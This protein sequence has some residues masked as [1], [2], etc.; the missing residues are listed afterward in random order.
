MHQ[1][2]FSKATPW[3]SE[4]SCSCLDV[5]DSRA[6]Q[7]ALK[8]APC[9]LRE[10][11][12]TAKIHKEFALNIFGCDHRN[13]AILQSSISK[14]LNEQAPCIVTSQQTLKLSRIL[15]RG[16]AFK[17]ILLTRIRNYCAVLAVLQ[18]VDMSVSL[19]RKHSCSADSEKKHLGPSPP[20]PPRRQ[21]TTP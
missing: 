8:R 21:Y 18:L 1:P 5:E 16:R 13:R 15:G 20:T 19:W 3:K 4:S 14:Y 6:V 9:R 11:V 2:L 17:T 10:L 7:K 12:F